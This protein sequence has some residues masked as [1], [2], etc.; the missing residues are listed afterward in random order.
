MRTIP[1]M[2][3]ASL[4]VYDLLMAISSAAPYIGDF[5]L[6]V[7]LQDP[8]ISR[9]HNYYVGCFCFDSHNGLDGSKQIL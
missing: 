4:A 6:A 5:P 1:N 3:V 9:F 2:F 8:P 7:Q